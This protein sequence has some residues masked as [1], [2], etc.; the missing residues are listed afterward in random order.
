MYLMPNV[1]LVPEAL[2]K[3]AEGII[4]IQSFHTNL[5]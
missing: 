3:Y 5:F 4:Y 1:F 2:A